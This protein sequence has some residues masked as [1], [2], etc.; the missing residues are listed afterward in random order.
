MLRCSIIIIINNYNDKKQG[1][2]S[3]KLRYTQKDTQRIH[4]DYSVGIAK[5]KYLV[6]L[7][8]ILNFVIRSSGAF[9]L[10]DS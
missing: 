10:E 7:S 4:N 1:N 2:S 8:K 3:S 6:A 5:Y 9:C